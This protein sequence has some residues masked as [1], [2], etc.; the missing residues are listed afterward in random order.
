M[1]RNVEKKELELFTHL[2][3]NELTNQLLEIGVTK[4]HINDHLVKYFYLIDK[5]YTFQV[6]NKNREY[7]RL[8]S[9]LLGSL[10]GKDY[11]KPIINNLINAGIIQ[12][13]KN[14]RNFGDIKE[15]KAYRLVN[16]NVDFFV[17]AFSAT[18]FKFVDK[19]INERVKRIEKDTQTLSRLFRTLS[20][21]ETSHIDQTCLSANELMFLHQLETYKFQTVGAKGKRVYNNFCNLPKSLRGCLRINNEN[22]A[23]VDVVC[24][25]M[26]FLASLVKSQLETQSITLENTTNHFIQLVTDGKL[27]EHLATEFDLNRDEAKDGIFQMVFSSNKFQSKIKKSFKAQFPQVLTVMAQIKE[28]DHKVLSHLM[29]QKEAEV[30]FRALDSIEYSKEVLSVHDSLYAGKSDLKTISDALIK[31]FQVEGINA[32]ININD[33]SKVKVFDSVANEIKDLHVDDDFGVFDIQEV[34]PEVEMFQLPLNPNDSAGKIFINLLKN[35]GIH[36]SM[37]SDSV[38]FPLKDKGFVIA[39]ASECYR[40]LRAT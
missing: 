24:S 37:K 9:I 39:T 12:L 25:Q 40:N 6:F 27:Y 5:M 2:T 4:R 33:Q 17:L 36:F 38:S 30:I 7:C 23:F 29:Q 13:I 3:V 10:L 21:I 20:N 28:K 18:D 34:K 35:N 16:E 19:I 26:I 11:Y 15:S 31:S 8:S 22:L 1:K 14:H 32:T